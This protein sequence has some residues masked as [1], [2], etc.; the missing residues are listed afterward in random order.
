VT[1]V[2]VEF[3]VGRVRGSRS[4]KGK[5]VL[6]CAVRRI[7][8]YV[9]T[10]VRWMVLGCAGVDVPYLLARSTFAANFMY[11]DVTVKTGTMKAR[12]DHALHTS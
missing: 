3:S 11:F 4:R 9:R 5:N 8:Q 10:Y 6:Y 1:C 12:V 2:T 7:R